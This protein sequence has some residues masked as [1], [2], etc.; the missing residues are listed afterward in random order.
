LSGSREKSAHSDWTPVHDSTDG[1]NRDKLI[2]QLT[3]TY[4][5]Q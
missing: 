4:I 1:K 2:P 5:K 3:K